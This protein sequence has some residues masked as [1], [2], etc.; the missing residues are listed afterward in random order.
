MKGELI[1]QSQSQFDALA[2]T[3]PREDIEFWFARDL[4]R[5]TSD[6]CVERTL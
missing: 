4:F 5:H 3:V 1:Q 2:Q 6:I